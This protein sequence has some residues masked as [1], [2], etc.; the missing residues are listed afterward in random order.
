M[1]QYSN[2][3]DFLNGNKSDGT[4]SH[5]AMN[6]GSYFIG[7]DSLDT[8]YDLYA[9][10]LRRRDKQFLTEVSTTVGP[11]RIDFDFIYEKD[12]K[13]HLHTRDQV[14]SFVKAYVG[15]LGKY[16][17]VPQEIDVYIMEKEEPTYN[18]KKDKMKSG[19][20]ILIPEIKT[21]KQVEQRVRRALIN[22]METFFPNL[23]LVDAWDKVYD[24]AVV[25][26]SAPWTLYG[27]QK[28]ENIDVNAMPYKLT[29][30][31]HWDGN[32]FQEIDG[33]HLP[34]DESSALI[35][36]LSIRRAESEET[37]P[38]DEGKQLY[39]SIRANAQETRKPSRG[40]PAERVE[41]TS[42]RGSS[43]NGRI[44]QSLDSDTRDYIRRHV[45]NLN[46]KR[47]DDYSEWIKVGQCLHNIHP[48]LLD[49]FLD[50]SAQNTEKYNES[51]CVRAWNSLTYRID[52]DRLSDQ[53]LRYWSREDNNENYLAIEDDNIYSLMKAACSL[54]EYDMAALIYGKFRDNYK[55]SDYK[56]NIW[57]RWAGHIWKE[58]DSGVDLLLRLSKEV[59]R[60]FVEKAVEIYNQMNRDQVIECSM[61]VDKKD[62]GKC[63]YCLLNAE[64]EAYERVFKQ[65]KKT[66]FK[67]NVMKECRELF[68]DEQFNKKLNA[69]NELIAFN[70]GVMEL[71]TCTFRQGRPEDYISYSTG[72]D[73]S[74]DRA[75]YEYPA[76]PQIE[77]F[78][79]QVLPV[80]TVR[81]YFVKHLATNLFGGNT[82]Q[83]FHILTGSG[84]N[85]K[86]M[87]ANLMAKALGDY[88]CTVPISLF[89]QKRASSSSAAPE[90]ARL[91]ARRF[92]TMQEPDEAV[93]INSGLMKQM[94][95]GEKMY[96][97]DLFKS[98]SEFEIVSKFH[99]A[100]NDKPK[101]NTTDGGTWR[102]LVVINFISK[103]VVNPTYPNEFPLDESIQFAVA[104]NEWAVPFLSYL[105]HILKTSPG[106]RKLEAP[107]EVLEYTREYQNENDM[108][109]KF[110]S[111]TLVRVADGEEIVPLD[112]KALRQRLKAW[113]DENDQKL[114]SP[115]E[116]EKRIEAQFGKY[117]NGGWTNIR[118]KND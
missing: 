7:E 114:I 63:D 34:P 87:I 35:R 27:S 108:I 106:I 64:K 42:S 21:R 12:I 54:T 83:K 105:V 46:P 57:Y 116:V 76:W 110:V 104:S 43:P 96:A 68:F 55:C 9:K 45:M 89:T 52:G 29:Y 11:C 73:Y 82:A 100:C 92:V 91:R 84:S 53:S 26:R 17:N 88:A 44:L 41:Q 2:L 112:K 78:I 23:P 77:K 117:R 28:P 50:F 24:E 56:Y 18:R 25:N 60:K 59:A 47:S 71:D 118:I 62:C 90:V 93:A 65:L 48:D 69:N 30:I 10:A 13:Q 22:Q 61:P 4:A 94:T 75:Y 86:S 15:E 36:T 67:S 70:N 102:R 58:T 3:R 103:F 1:S 97:R 14:K 99:L 40:R 66:S 33:R 79:S 16:V 81:D 115:A 109:A 37:P 8:F 95:S 85:G 6:G 31:L 20:H 32:E 113:K 38:T 72:I 111:E 19:I 5:T 39:E 107:Q 74:A 51:E 101:I 80:R 98:G 49:V